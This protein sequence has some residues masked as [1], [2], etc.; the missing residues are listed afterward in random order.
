MSTTLPLITAGPIFLKDVPLMVEA[1]NNFLRCSTEVNLS[2][3]GVGLICALPNNANVSKR[4]K[5]SIFLIV[6]LIIC[7]F[8]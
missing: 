2:E 5:L 3:A 7:I 4:Q 6:V 8:K 1:S